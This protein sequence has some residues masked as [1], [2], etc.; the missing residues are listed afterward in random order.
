MEKLKS[1]LK[2]TVLA[3]ALVVLTGMANAIV[4]PAKAVINPL[5]QTVYAPKND[6]SNNTVLAA[7]R[8]YTQSFSNNSPVWTENTG[9]KLNLSS[10]TAKTFGLAVSEDGKKLFVAINDAQQSKLRIYD[11]GGDGLPTGTYKDAVWTPD[12]NGWDSP[13]GIALAGDRVFMADMQTAKVHVFDYDAASQNWKWTS[14]LTD[15]LTG[16]GALYGVTV[17]PKVVNG[18][19][20]T[21]PLFVTRKATSS[22]AKELF[23]YAYTVNGSTKTI[24]YKNGANLNTPTYVAASTNELYVAVKDT[25]A[26]VAAF[27][28]DITA[29]TLSS[30]PVINKGPLDLG[31]VALDLLPNN[32]YLFYT[33]PTDASGKPSY[34]Y[35]VTLPGTTPAALPDSPINIMEVDGVIC[36]PDGRRTIVSN[37][38]TGEIIA[39]GTGNALPSG[40]LAASVASITPNST[41][42][43]TDTD[44]TIT[45]KYFLANPTVSLLYNNVNYP[46]T[47]VEVKSSTQ[48]TA[49]VDFPGTPAIPNTTTTY[50][51]SIV[52]PNQGNGGLLSNAFTINELVSNPTIST[53]NP[54]SGEQGQTLNVEVTG[55]GYYSGTA[56]SFSG[57]GIT[58]N[59]TT[60][61]SATKVTANISIASNATLSARNVTVT[62][63]GKTPATKTGAF[64]VTAPVATPTISSVNPTSGEQGQTFLDVEVNGTGYTAATTVSFSGTGITKNST[65]FNSASKMTVNISIANNAT[66]SARDVTVTNPGKTPATKTGAFTVTA[67]TPA[68][69]ISTVVPSSGQQGQTL[70][71]EI[72]GT[73]Y[74][75][76]TYVEFYGTGININSTTLNSATKITVNITIAGN[77]ALGARDVIVTN[78]GKTPATK[79]DGFTVTT[80]ADTIAPA[81]IT[82]LTAHTGTAYG[83]VQLT[84]TAVGDDNQTGTA[85]HYIVKYSKNPITTDAEFNAASTY[86]QNWTPKVA[87]GA[88]DYTLTGL[89]LLAG[90]LVYFTIKAQDEVPNTGALG[91]AAFTFVK[92]SI[93]V[94]TVTAL[95]PNMGPNSKTTDIVIEGTNFAS[96]LRVY[97]ETTP[98]QNLANVVAVKGDRIE[99]TVPKNLT[100]GTY[101]IR[102]EGPG[103]TSA[104]VKADLFT[105]M[106]GPENPAVPSQVTDLKITNG[107]TQCTLDWTNPADTDMAKL[108]VRRYASAFPL[109]YDPLVGTVVYP[110]SGTHIPT[111]GKAMK[112]TDTGLTNNLKYYYVVFIKDTSDN[113]S[114]VDYHLPSVNAALGQPTA[115]STDPVSSINIVR[116]GDTVGSGVTITW[117]TNPANTAVDVY[118]LNC[119]IDQG[120]ASY[121]SYFTTDT[122]KWTK[123]A[124]G[125]NLTNGTY[126]IP[127]LVGTG[128]A[129][130]YKLITHGATLQTSDLLTNVVGKFD[131]IVGPSDTQADKFFVSLPLSP[132]APKTNSVADLFGAQVAEGDGVLLFNMN[133]DVT[134]GSLYNS[135]AWAAFPGVPAIDN[136]SAGRAY[137]Y[138]TQ[139]EKYITI[140]GK[141][142]TAATN[143]LSL[144]GG[145]DSVKDQAAVAEWIGNAYPT[146]VT[147]ALSGL[148]N[149]TSQGTSPLDGGTAYQFNA[150]ADLINGIDGMAVNTTGG[151]VNGTLSAPSTLQLVPGKGYMLNEPVKQSFSWSQ[152][153]PY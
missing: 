130:Y 9:S 7:I 66:L 88:E 108:E 73:G 147:L 75:N 62:N 103:G 41:V 32:G 33:Y 53:V 142:P 99:A 91:N 128:S 151:W 83:T 115:G 114:A 97:I 118:V 126:Q 135:G 82:T 107:D 98:E 93:P 8:V 24:T 140:V 109:S 105:V 26:D 153:K 37:S 23:M 30:K 132:I 22:T 90:Q 87:G 119:A 136:L 113:W 12:T 44:V 120:A 121:T 77:A 101:D 2:F 67:P 16:L 127:N 63:P 14:D 149:A 46:L 111:P 40:Y 81:A 133:K 35:R 27:S 100:P 28:Y 131:L 141:V 74:N 47:N 34:Y 89:D 21:Y 1:G 86:T 19:T 95:Y 146:P 45:G 134:S 72:T 122:S 96:I 5:T 64:T 10:L 42:H 13:A 18:S 6:S 31:W 55:T 11:L 69:T 102:V 71:V 152:A 124:N 80:A 59:S 125:D 20:T 38:W 110:A 137:G 60:F 94:P 52:N 143:D 4:L 17:G 50:G 25:A 56:V 76:Q 144:A 48:L 57:T 92:D 112:M 29:G 36:T 117:T 68:P 148:T 78:P 51:V 61:N 3:L 150:N 54:T 43:G 79:A 39:Y 84:W 138:L 104:K 65:V 15:Q 123:A 49:K 85:T 129:A 145:W 58:V 70:N 139:A 106:S 116:D